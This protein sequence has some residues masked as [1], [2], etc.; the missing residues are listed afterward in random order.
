MENSEPRDDKTLED[1]FAKFLSLITKESDEISDKEIFFLKQA[2]FV[3]AARGFT[4]ADNKDREK[5]RKAIQG[6]LD[7]LSNLNRDFGLATCQGTV[8]HYIY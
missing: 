5:T 8:R 3:G 1:S 4:L 7:E 6:E 2:Y